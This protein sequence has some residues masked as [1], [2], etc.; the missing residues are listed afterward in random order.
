MAGRLS[1][2]SW[3]H[4]AQT[5]A[6]GRNAKFLLRSKEEGLGKVRVALV[7]SG[8]GIWG[9]AGIGVLKAL[10][11]W[12]YQPDLIVGTSS[13]AIIGSLWAVGMSVDAMTDLALSLNKRDVPISWRTIGGQLLGQRR[14]PDALFD[15]APLWQ[16]LRP[17]L[18]GISVSAVPKPLWVVATSLTDRS[19][20]VL[21][22][23]IDKVNPG[24]LMGDPD[25]ELIDAVRASSAVPGFFSPVMVR[26]QVL[27]DG[28]VGDD[29]P[30][31]VAEMLGADRA[32]GLWIDEPARWQL[33]S[34]RPHAFHVLVESMAVMIREISVLRQSTL[35]MPHWDLRIELTGHTVFARIAEIIETGYNSAVESKDAIDRLFTEPGRSRIG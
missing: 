20:I 30:L 10:E 31:D 15:A 18:S 23:R 14:L 4:G 2:S 21:G 1:A 34:P 25:M 27:V 6:R 5:E 24:F 13:G 26:D 8:G 7:L 33:P 12:G 35:R 11:E 3:A 19:P 17:W 29:Y 9:T 32:L 22:R 28:G 16:K